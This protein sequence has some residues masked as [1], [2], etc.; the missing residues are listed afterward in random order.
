MTRLAAQLERWRFPL[1]DC[2]LE[3]DH[4]RALG[5]ES[6]PRRKF[7]RAVE[8]L[9]KQPPPSWQLDEDLRGSAEHAPRTL[10]R[11]ES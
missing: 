6:M 11:A 5:A 10:L 3:T 8:R 9:V 1:I 2:Q 7:V 4:L